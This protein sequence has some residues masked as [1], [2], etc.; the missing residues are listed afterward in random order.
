LR[1]ALLTPQSISLPYLHHNYITPNQSPL[2]SP[3]L[4]APQ[5]T[6]RT[7][8]LLM[9]KSVEEVVLPA[10]TPDAASSVPNMCPNEPHRVAE[11][12]REER[13]ETKP[14]RLSSGY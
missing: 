2:L 8:K 6:G 5:S 10:L 1:T 11:K 3:S 9:S 14:Q 12:G 7:N 13:R 4:L